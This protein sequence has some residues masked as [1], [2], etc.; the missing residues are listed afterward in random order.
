MR[1]YQWLLL[2]LVWVTVPIG[3][4]ARQQAMG[5]AD[6]EPRLV[7]APLTRTEGAAVPDGQRGATSTTPADRATPEDRATPA[8]RATAVAEALATRPA[9]IAADGTRLPMT[10]WHPE[11]D[12]VRAVVLAVHGFNDYA[13]AFRFAGAAWA[14]QG[15]LTY[16]YDQRGFGATE[17]FGIWAG[18][19]TYRRDLAAAVQAVRSRHPDLPLTLV[20]ESMGG[21]VVITAT[22][23]DD[24]MV[25]P[26][27]YDSLVL[28]G[29][30]TWARQTMV[31]VQRW[32]LD[33]VRAVFPGL[34]LTGDGIPVSPTD[35]REVMRDLGRDPLVVKAN[36]VDTLDGLTTLMSEAFARVP[37]L[38]GPALVMYGEQEQIIP[39]EPVRLTLQR[40]P[41]VP[42][43]RT[44]IY[45][46]GWHMLL[47]DLQRD[48][49]IADAARFI[50]DPAA[51]LPS[52]ADGRVWPSM[53]PA[54][55]DA[56]A[57]GGAA[58]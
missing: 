54:E 23:G 32:A 4:T 29:P 47:R 10:V 28:V 56:G 20:G 31:W 16:A 15:I 58:R 41:E 3:C 18:A 2:L 9:L 24:P 45:P 55:Q 8:D 43:I 35:N 26:D 11:P 27:A 25:P 37:D 6:T 13:N 5:D 12:P 42:T 33:V 51:P 38:R 57:T 44:A 14:E 46:D 40:L 21:A 1:V 17:D 50:L 48:V 49:P 30:A 7:P 53:A 52:G 19:D 34:R 22:A 39:D 36:R